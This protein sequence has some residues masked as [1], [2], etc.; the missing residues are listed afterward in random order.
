MNQLASGA[1]QGQLPSVG[2]Q[3]DGW[4]GV[5]LR[6]GVLF[7]VLREF[8]GGVAFSGRKRKNSAKISPNPNKVAQTGQS[9]IKQIDNANFF[10]A[11]HPN[12]P[13]QFGSEGRSAMKFLDQ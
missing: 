10:R 6:N 11:P 8:L 13:H 1:I 9:I 2:H 7:T 5:R 3:K 12:F 4:R